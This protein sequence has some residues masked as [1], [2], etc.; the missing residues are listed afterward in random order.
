MRCYRSLRSL[1]DRASDASA[2]TLLVVP[3]SSS[4]SSMNG[5]TSSSGGAALAAGAAHPN[6]HTAPGAV[7]DQTTSSSRSGG[8]GSLGSGNWLHP[9]QYA[10]TAASPHAPA[11]LLSSTAYDRARLADFVA[12]TNH[13]AG[14][15][16]TQAAVT[17]AANMQTSKATLYAS[18]LTQLA[19]EMAKVPHIAWQKVSG[20]P[21][22][23]RKSARSR[24]MLTISILSLAPDLPSLCPMPNRSTHAR[25]PR[26]RWPRPPLVDRL[27][28]DDARE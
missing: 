20:H 1:C 6:G 21:T 23:S 5:A 15:G 10:H 18:A 22:R 7:A 28:A 19:K 4:S 24:S 12:T 17:A 25:C 14:A 2:C 8:S 26:T 16:S 11:G 27:G 13:Q 3:R 9:L